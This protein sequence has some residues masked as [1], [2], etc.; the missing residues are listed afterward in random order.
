MLWK[1]KI[2]YLDLLIIIFFFIILFFK[3]FLRGKLNIFDIFVLFIFGL[4]LEGMILIIKLINLL[5]CI[6]DG[7]R[8]VMIFIFFVGSLVFFFVFLRVVFIID[9]LFLFM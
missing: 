5:G 2:M 1:K 7:G 8:I 4:K 3:N 6:K 9:W